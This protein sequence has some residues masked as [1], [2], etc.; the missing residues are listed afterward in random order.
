MT[1]RAMALLNTYLMAFYGQGRWVEHYHA[2]QIYLNKELITSSKISFNEVQDKTAAFM[3]EFT[4]VAF[5]A[6][7]YIFNRAEYTSGVLQLFQESYHKEHCGDVLIRLEPG[8]IEQPEKAFESDIFGLSDTR[9][10]LSFYGWKVGRG[11][12]NAPVF[13][14]DIVPTICSEAGL[15]MPNSVTGTPRKLLTP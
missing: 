5:A 4:G 13:I 11:K 1:D 14:K 10:P 3:T 9:V 2:Q 8:W 15:P 6:P 12:E 7:S